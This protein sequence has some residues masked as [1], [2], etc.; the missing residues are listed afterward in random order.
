MK[1]YYVGEWHTHPNGSTKYSSTDLNAMI[2]IA[3][4][5]NVV[6]ENPILLILSINK[7]K[8]Y[9]FSFYLYASEKLIEYDKN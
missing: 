3:K 9:K 6:I 8:S 1:H 5:D 7:D 4:D 2:K